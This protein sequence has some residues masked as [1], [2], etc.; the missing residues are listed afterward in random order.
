MLSTSFSSIH[1]HTHASSRELASPLPPLVPFRFP[2]LIS[3]HNRLSLSVTRTDTN[4]IANLEGKGE[5]LIASKTSELRQQ[6]PLQNRDYPDTVITSLVTFRKSYRTV[7]NPVCYNQLAKNYRTT[8][9]V[10]KSVIDNQLVKSYRST[11]AVIKPVFDS[12]LWKATVPTTPDALVCL[13]GSL[14]K[15]S[16]SERLCRIEFCQPHWSGRSR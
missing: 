2:I 13:S 16:C 3:G 15:Q 6:R 7:I 4:A 9:S 10:I 1:F 5:T 14:T 8:P 12:Q 11:P